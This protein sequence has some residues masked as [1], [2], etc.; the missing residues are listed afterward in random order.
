MAKNEDLASISE[1]EATL[2]GEEREGPG[3][4]KK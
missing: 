1:E 3:K 4:R 2:D